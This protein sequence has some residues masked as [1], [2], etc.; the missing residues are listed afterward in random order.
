MSK[1][2]KK[3]F[4]K[5]LAEA[6]LE[7]SENGILIIDLNQQVV[8][9]NSRFAELWHVPE[10]LLASHDDKKLLEYVTDQLQDP[11]EF[12]SKVEYL[13]KHPKKESK[14]KVYFKDGRIFL[15]FTRPMYVEGEVVARVWSFLD[16]T[17]AEESRVELSREAGF[18]NTIIKT[19]PDMI[20]LKDPDGVYLA[21][22]EVFERFFGAREKEIVGKTDYDFVDKELAD[23]FRANDLEAIKAG[24]PRVN[25]EWISFADDGHKAYLETTKTPMFS[26]E[27]ELIGVLG[28]GHDITGRF[29][30]EK[31]LHLSEKRYQ[32]AQR[33]AHLGS[34]ELDLANNNLTWSEEVFRIFEI[35]SDVFP[36]SYEAFLDRVHP[37]DREMVNQT[38]HDSVASKISYQI[39][40]RLLFDDGRLKYVLERGRTFYDD[41][42]NAVRSIG[43]VLDITKRKLAEIE[44]IEREEQLTAIFE[45]SN[46]GIMFLTGYRIFAKG[47]QRLADILGYDSADEMLGFSMRELHLSEDRFKKF[48]EKYYNK[49]KEK[50]LF[51]VE[52]QLKRKDGSP[53]WCQLSGSAIDTSMPADLNKGVIWVIDDIEKRKELESK[54]LQNSLQYEA[55]K[56]STKD[57][58]WV[59]D[60]KGYILESNQSYC[61][62]SGFSREELLTMHVTQLDVHDTPDIARSRIETT[63]KQGSD[64]FETE[65][66]R[67]DGSIWPVQVS[68][69][70]S[71]MD[72]GCFFV[73]LRDISDRKNLEKQISE[74]NVFLK[75]EVEKRTLQLEKARLNAEQANFEKS[76]FLANMSHELRTPMHAILSFAALG[77]KHVENAKVERFLQ[78][79]RTSGI[80]LT[81]LLN[82]LLDLSKLEAGKMQ[83]E[84]IEQDLVTLINQV[85]LELKS[86]LAEKKISLTLNAEDSVN[87][88]LDNKLMM[89]VFVNLFSN[90][91]KFSPESSEIKVELTTSQSGKFIQEPHV[92]VRVVDQG[93]GIPVDQLDD[94]FDKFVQSSKTRSQS[95]G[96]GLGL[97]ITKEIVEL[98]HGR[99]WAESPIADHKGSAF[100]MEIPIIPPQLFPGVDEA[101]KSHKQWKLLIEG[102]LQG[103][104]VS[105]LPVKTLADEH[106][107]PLGKW[108]DSI[109]SKEVV[110][111]SSLKDLHRSH[112]EFHQVA[113]EMVALFQ[114]DQTENLAELEKRFEGASSQVIDILQSLKKQ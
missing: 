27:G 46:V 5:S 103:E 102:A 75:K 44:L 7:A 63:V 4:S 8:Q 32:E 28:I 77:L 104:S 81:A 114:T 70:F 36:A 19:L 50:D 65:H 112:K 13:Y 109:D 42:D 89:Q 1:F 61:N 93:V 45:N 33:Q 38:Y 106:L 18:K 3:E 34:W 41:E 98:H 29:E 17:Q 49:L 16:I 94:V 100:C 87:C 108:L 40:H 31:S 35:D 99:I 107:C 62:Y 85:K 14:D 72:N 21:C 101:I 30:A 37:D 54:A 84:L 105:G 79:I 20:W 82:D 91:I 24:K 56:E 22:N 97:P 80:R 10:K 86:L 11:E 53:V 66:R 47:N 78:N 25:E 52:Y 43:T 48:G 76:R 90:A 88:S 73:F 83:A 6:A 15:R 110:D 2:S 58:F 39:E 64:I 9:F 69:S 23:F 68:I 71:D 59:V 67:K 74:H 51:Q 95:G 111:E 96:T 55:V 12:L 60:E 57:G 113:A 92:L 26:T